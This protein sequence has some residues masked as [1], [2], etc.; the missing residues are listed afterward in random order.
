MGQSLPL[1]LASSSPYRKELLERLHLEFSVDSPSIDETPLTGEKPY[2]LALRLSKLKA[3]ACA[4]NHP[5]AVIIGSDQVLDLE[6]QCLGKPGN[7]ENAIAQLLKT[8][9]KTLV[10]QTAVSV[11]DTSG[12]V[13]S[14]VI[15]TTI[16]M[17]FLSQLAI[18]AYVDLEKPFN[19]AGAA[20]IEKMGIALI[21][22]FSSTDPTAIIGLP[23]IALTDMLKKAGI[24]VLPG[25]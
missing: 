21:K 5:G 19:C 25:I 4:K 12:Q 18:E 20:K 11:I 23:L 3:L 15:P 1:V 10:F 17:R 2:D 24:T 7:R 6:G 14:N 22:E 16:K 13:Q 9:G 8:S